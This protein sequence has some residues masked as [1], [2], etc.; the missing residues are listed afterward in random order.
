MVLKKHAVER[1]RKRLVLFEKEK[2][3]VGSTG[4]LVTLAHLLML[5]EI[6]IVF[7]EASL[8]QRDVEHAYADRHRVEAIDLG[9]DADQEKLVTIIDEAPDGARVL[10]NVPGGRFEDLDR[11][12]EFIRFVIED[13]EEA[14]DIGVDIVWTMGLDQASRATLDAMLA[15]NPPGRVLLNLPEWHGPPEKF[16]LIDDDVLG[17]IEKTGGDLFCCPAMPEHIYDRFRS[18]NIGLDQILGHL[19]RGERARFR[20]WQRDV[21]AA[22]EGLF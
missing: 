5:R 17:K 14:I 6:P 1:A 18:S 15:G 13:E 3:G 9:D 16:A 2:G 4:T 19:S 20:K 7:I 11:A 8:S 22:M 10:V 12:H 21:E